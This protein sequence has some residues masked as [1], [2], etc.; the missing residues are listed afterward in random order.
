MLSRA[1]YRHF[2]LLVS[3]V[4][5]VP[6]PV[7]ATEAIAKASATTRVWAIRCQP[8]QLVNGSPIVVEV[9]PPVRLT[10]LSAQL[11]RT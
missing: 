7:H 6:Y 9:A 1:L 2:L 8:V 4:L 10:K 3:L 11:A 5:V